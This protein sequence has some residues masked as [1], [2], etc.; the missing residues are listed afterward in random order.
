MLKAFYDTVGR[1]KV[2]NVRVEFSLSNALFCRAWG[3][4]ALDAA[5]LAR[6][7]ERMRQLAAQ[8]L[9]IEKKPVDIEDARAF[10]S[11]NGMEDKA[12]VL[13]YRV[14][15]RVNLYTLDGFTDYFYGYMVPHTG[16]LKWFALEPF[17]DGFVLRP[18]GA[19]AAWPVR[20]LQKGLSGH[21]RR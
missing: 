9:P 4:F 21:A 14:S 11:A 5:L 19:G 15:S 17:E 1:D 12:R 20:A 3:D 16:Y 18:G 2:K 6:V 8:A 10:F 13:K 7:E